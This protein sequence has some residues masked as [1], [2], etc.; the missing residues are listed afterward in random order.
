MRETLHIR[1]PDLNQDSDPDSAA[2]LACVVAYALTATEPPVSVLVRLAPL[3]EVLEL[4]P[5]K[6]IRLYAPA[7][8]VR[9]LTV[10]VPAKQLS[11]AALAVPYA[12]EDQFAE[13]VETLHFALAPAPLANGEWPVAVLSAEHMRAWLAPFSVRGLVPEALIPETLALPWRSDDDRWTV[14]AEPGHVTV[15]AGATAGFGCLAEDL[16]LFLG[17]LEGGQ[18]HPLRILISQG[19]D[20]DFSK[21]ERDVELLPGLGHPLEAL[22]RHYRAAQSINLLQGAFSMRQALA[23]EWQTWKLPALLLAGVFAIG[24][25]GNGLSAWLLSS[26]V[27]Q[28]EAANEARFRVLFPAEQRVVN[29]SVQAEQQFAALQGGSHAASLLSLIDAFAGGLKAAP[30]LHVEGIQYREGALYLSLTGTDLSALDQLKNHYASGHGGAK[31]DVQSA[32][33]GDGGVQIQIKLSPS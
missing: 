30:T 32:N 31:L 22:V 7:Q 9:L 27:Q 13:D 17:L 2:L 3:A 14:L 11:K 20:T 15:R 18:Q 29:L 33:S 6:L 28:Q 26:Q 1:L 25:V 16:E 5:S 23:R 19:V 21:L 4:A 8:D 12:L 24:V 10:A